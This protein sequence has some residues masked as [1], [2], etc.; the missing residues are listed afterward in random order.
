MGE[1]GGDEG[2]FVDGSASV[3][4]ESS[5]VM[6]ETVFRESSS[7]GNQSWTLEY[8]QWQIDAE[9]AAHKR[10]QEKKDNDLR[11]FCI[12]VVLGLLIVVLC[13][14]ALVGLLNEDPSIRQ[15]AQNIFT[16]LI[17]GLLG[18]IAGYFTAKSGS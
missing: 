4:A 6:S 13:A 10:E 16:T 2:R 1:A 18:A 17:G 11:R 9:T 15:W 14:S 5:V 12:R 7:V 3:S 8:G